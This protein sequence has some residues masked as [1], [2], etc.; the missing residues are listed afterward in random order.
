MI[1]RYCRSIRN[2]RGITLVELIVSLGVMSLVSVGV[3]SAIYGLM[4]SQK[5]IMNRIDAGEFTGALAR[6]M[7]EKM[8]C[9]SYLNG[10]PT[11]ADWTPL[12]IPNYRGYGG[13]GGALGPGTVLGGTAANPTMWVQNMQWRMKPGIPAETVVVDGEPKARTIMQVRIELN[14]REAGRVSP[15]PAREVEFVVL[16]NAAN[17]VSDCEGTPSMEDACKALGTTYDPATA[18]CLPGKEECIMRGT[19]INSYCNSTPCQATSK[20]PPRT[21]EYTGNYTCPSGSNPVTTFDY[22]W[23]SNEQV[24]KK[25][26]RQVQNTIKA[27]ICLQCPE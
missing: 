5:G 10:T 23:T 27:Y 8:S 11:P 15:L 18:S 17:Q 13:S 25:S 6:S 22:T 9:S 12:T 1:L 24:G 14:T 16:R 26:F 20:S 2:S 3:A 19:Y 4:T 7:T 21:N